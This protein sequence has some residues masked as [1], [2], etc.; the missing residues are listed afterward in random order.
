MFRTAAGNRCFSEGPLKLSDANNWY[1]NDFCFATCQSA[2]SSS[3]CTELFVSLCRFILVTVAYISYAS[4]K[5][6]ADIPQLGED[7]TFEF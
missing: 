3:S 5:H 1:K 6:F 2:G 4:Q 7:F